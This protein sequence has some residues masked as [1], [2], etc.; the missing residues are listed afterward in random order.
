MTKKILYSLGI[1]FS[2]IVLSASY[3]YDNPLN[4]FADSCPS[5]FI[6]MDIALRDVNQESFHEIVPNVPYIIDPYDLN[7]YT[8]HDSTEV[9]IMVPENWTKNKG[10]LSYCT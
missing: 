9:Y 1:T 8:A 7:T 4:A 2:L 5:S 6:W 10:L 3:K